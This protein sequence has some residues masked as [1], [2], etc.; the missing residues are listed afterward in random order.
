MCSWLS[1][2][3]ILIDGEDYYKSTDEDFSPA[4]RRR[5]IRKMP[6]ILQERTIFV[7]LTLDWMKMS[8]EHLILKLK[9]K[10]DAII[11]DSRIQ[12]LPWVKRISYSMFLSLNHQETFMIASESNSSVTTIM[13]SLILPLPRSIGNKSNNLDIGASRE[14]FLVKGKTRTRLGLEPWDNSVNNQAEGKI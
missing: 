7:I 10:K 3:Y 14:E 11:F 1:N 2:D 4:L 12:I 9:A 6:A 13:I 5:K 8:W